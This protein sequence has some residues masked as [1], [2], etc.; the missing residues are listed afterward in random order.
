[1]EETSPT[2]AKGRLHDG[3]STITGRKLGRGYLQT[4]FHSG[5]MFDTIDLDGGSCEPAS[6]QDRN[7]FG[8]LAHKSPLA[9]PNK[10]IW[11]PDQGETD[12]MLGLS[13]EGNCRDKRS[14]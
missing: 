12:T 7:E 4:A 6:R 2:A 11:S 5:G 1:M 10:H 9:S 13:V 3:G 14:T 8:N